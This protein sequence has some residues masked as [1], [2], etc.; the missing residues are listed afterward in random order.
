MADLAAAAP[1]HTDTA[2]NALT[3]RQSDRRYR[4]LKTGLRLS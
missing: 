2:L 3:R 1:R 4:P